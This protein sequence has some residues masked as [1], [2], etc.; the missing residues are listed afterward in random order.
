MD[1]ISTPLDHNLKLQFSLV[2][3]PQAE[4]YSY[5]NQNILRQDISALS[6]STHFL[7]EWM[8]LNICFLPHV[9]YIFKGEK[10]SMEIKQNEKNPSLDVY[11]FAHL[12]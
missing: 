1:P 9:K 5:K 11:I 3:N 2:K 8:C 6:Q 7:V 4:S 12:T 10:K